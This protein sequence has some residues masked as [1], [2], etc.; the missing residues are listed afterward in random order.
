MSRK[1]LDDLTADAKQAGAKGLVWIKVTAEGVSSPV[2]K[3]LTAIHERLLAQ[4]RGGAGRPHPPRRRCLGG[5]RDRSRPAPRGAGQA[6]QAHP[7]GPR[8]LHVGDRFSARGV[9][10]GRE[11]LGRRPPSLHRPARRG[12]SPLLESDPGLRGPRPTIS[13]S[14]ARRRPEAPSASISLRCRRAPLRSSRHLQGRG[15]GA[16]RFLLEALEFGAPPMGASPSASTALP[17]AWWARNRSERSSRS[18]RPRRDVP[19]H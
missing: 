14:T 12:I 6:L 5:G 4:H 10:R 1:E 17:P 19:A 18:P 15:P 3:F 7:G 11:A 16:L 2:A 9:E 13:C 8:R